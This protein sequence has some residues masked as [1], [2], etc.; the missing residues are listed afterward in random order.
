MQKHIQKSRVGMMAYYLVWLHL[1]CAG[2]SD[3]LPRIGV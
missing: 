3:D 1:Q 2:S